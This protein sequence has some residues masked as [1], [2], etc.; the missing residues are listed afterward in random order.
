MNASRGIRTGAWI[1][2]AGG[3]LRIVGSFAT[4]LVVSDVAR[5]WA[6]VGIDVCL[7]S[8]LV[9]LYLAWRQSMRSLGRIGALVALAGLGAGRIV[10]AITDR[11]LYPAT[12]AAVAIGVL[13]LAL[14]GWR[15]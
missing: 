4:S 14:S 8:G 7:A 9:S 12:A 5:T 13:M 6:Y 1:G 15:A 11:N 2:T 3:A 10:P